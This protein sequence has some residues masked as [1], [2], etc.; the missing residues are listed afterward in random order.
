MTAPHEEMACHT[1]LSPLNTLGVPPT[2]VH[3]TH[4]AT[5]GHEPAPIPVSKLDTV[6]R[7]CDF[8]G[9]PYPI[10]TLHGGD[11]TAIAIGPTAGLVQ[12]FGHSWAACAAC[13]THIDEGRT[14]KVID[15]AVRALGHA[16][17]PQARERI[18][19][20]H[21]AFLN[22]RLPGRTLITTT[23]WPA[24]TITPGEL[25][26]VRDRLTRFYR[27]PDNL[28]AALA[29]TDPRDQIA[30]G[31]ER[32]HLYWIDNDFTDLA[33]HAAAQLPDIRI[34]RDLIPSA[35]GML[36]W[37]RPVTHRQLTGASWTDTIDG[38]HV[39]LYRTIGAG[40]H[41]KP[42]QRLR[43]Q[44]GWLAPMNAAH[45][46]EQHLIPGDHPAAA[47]ISTWLLIAQQTAEVTTTGVDKAVA[48]TYARTNRPVPELRIVRIR[49]RRTNPGPDEK[50]T[51]DSQ[52]RS[53]TSRFWVS[54]HWRNQAHGPG[55]SL[56][57][58]V[59]IH[60]FLR[61]PDDAPIKLS[62]TVRM[63]SSR[64]PSPEEQ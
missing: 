35:D 18:E 17:H 1:C 28:P 4:L 37:P 56:R 14:D 21:Q 58:P 41:G 47:L 59:Y 9:D 20:L 54:G 26:K 24:T 40:L 7:S 49:G 15:R 48:K 64:R 29:I 3:P 36:I 12:D 16:N 55:R 62:T 31:L 44:V 46:S 25:P 13:Q 51:P 52:E 2:Y 63:L 23:A 5:D 43:E 8:C 6:R 61:G 32:S 10:W 50:P 42:L 60:P 30:S 38:W 53:Q 27:S 45:L 34:G 57:R 39:V 19:E 22:A 33:E 11:V